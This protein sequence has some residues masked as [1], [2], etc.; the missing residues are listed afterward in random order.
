MSA[1]VEK[2]P[3]LSDPKARFRNAPRN[4]DFTIDQDWG[5]YTPAEHDRWDRLFKRSQAILRNRACDEFVAMIEKL[6]L[7]ES[8][9]P[10]MDKL[11]D[12]LTKLTGWRV[13]PV[14]ELVPDDI[15]FNH[16][17][18]RRFPAGAFIRSESGDGLP[19]GARRVSLTYSGTFRSWP[20]GLRGFHA[21]LW[22]RRQSGAG[23]WPLG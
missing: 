12:R 10:D 11:S 7:S 16:L 2:E 17:A 18:N 4:P 3:I 23:A 13:V 9:I 22:T 15:F 5:R 21:G 1:A 19:A 14:I 20:S 6:K 8:G